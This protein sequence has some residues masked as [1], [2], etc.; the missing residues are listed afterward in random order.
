MGMCTVFIV[1]FF[2]RRKQRKEHIEEIIKV[3]EIPKDFQDA[4]NDSAHS[5]APPAK[6]HLRS[7]RVPAVEAGTTE[8]Y[9]MPAVEPVG[10]ELN[11]PMET[12]MRDDWP[13][14]P[15][16]PMPLS[17]LSG[18]FAAVELRDQRNGGDVSPRH[19]TFYH[20]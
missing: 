18:L 5:P 9:E 2:T 8:I 12:R 19:N 14:S 13:V 16:R 15:L 10:S 11:T 1:I 7:E 4:D 6:V 3:V 17:P 20:A